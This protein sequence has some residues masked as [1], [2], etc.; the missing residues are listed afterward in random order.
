MNS[1]VRRIALTALLAALLVAAPGIA[2]AFDES[3]STI[4]ASSEANCGGCHD[5]WPS[6]TTGTGDNERI[7]VHGGYTTT[8][9]KCT[10]CHSVHAAPANSSV[11]LP[12]STVKATCFTCH[13]GTQGR[14]VYGAIA[15]RGLSVGG[16]HSVEETNVVPG[17]N[18]NTGGPL[19]VAFAGPNGT[20]SCTD[21][22]SPHGANIVAPFVRE[23]ART[24]L[25]VPMGSTYRSSQI[26]KQRPGNATTAT[27]VYGS[28]WCL[29]CHKGR[30]AGLSATHNHPADSAS[31]HATPFNYSYVARL[32]AGTNASVT[33]TGSLGAN[34]GGYLMPWPRTPQQTGHAPICQQCH[35][36][37][38]NPGSLSTTGNAGTVIPFTVTATDGTVGSNNPRFQTFP[39]ETTNFRML[40]EAD[41]TNYTDNLCLNC[42]P[43]AQLP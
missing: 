38:R 26:L 40:V 30:D 1:V 41:A 3:T 16:N 21:C 4:P 29:G 37:A 25:N 9:S 35:E 39:H 42:H 31:T 5:P 33:T 11:L 24:G 27:V 18:A 8:T 15:A 28:D 13:D 36:D 17:G 23:R 10:E 32:N 20:M 34:N 12:G 2:F 19:S 7:G 6:S 14:G 43:L 22:H